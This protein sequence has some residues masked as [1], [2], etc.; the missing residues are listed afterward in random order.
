MIAQLRDRVDGVVKVTLI[1]LMGASVLNVLWQVFSRYVLH[2]PSSWTEEL[3]RYL[4][5]WVSLLGAAYAVRL[6][7]HLAIDLAP[8]SLRGRARAWLQRLIHGCIFLFA[9]VVMV[10]GGSQLVDLALRMNQIS[11]ALQVKIAYMYLVLP[12]SGVLILFYSG[13]FLW[14]SFQ[15][16]EGIEM[17][18]KP[19]SEM[20]KTAGE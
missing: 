20:G 8:K 16:P 17:E 15:S 19:A 13:I 10:V 4:L 7:M 18:K 1:V 2:H 14:E 3:S 5:I 6:K 9:L 12:L 11:A